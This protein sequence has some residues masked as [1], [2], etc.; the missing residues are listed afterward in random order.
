MNDNSMNK[1]LTERE[2]FIDKLNFLLE[3]ATQEVDD[4]ILFQ[5]NEE[6]EGFLLDY[7][8]YYDYED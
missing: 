1:K 8:N 4:E 6:L 7:T 3:M 2:K 5:Y